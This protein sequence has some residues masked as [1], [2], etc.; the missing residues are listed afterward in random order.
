MLGVKVRD[1]RDGLPP[2]VQALLDRERE[3]P[4]LQATV[5]ARV[6]ARARGA[7]AAAPTPARTRPTR[8]RWALVAASLLMA[9][10]VAGAAVYQRLNTRL[11]MRRA[12]PQPVRVALV[13]PVAPIP[14]AAAKPAAPARPFDDGG[15]DELRLLRQA[16]AAVARQDYTSALTS[17]EEHARRF[18]NGRLAEER[19]ALRVK[20]LAGL[21][22]TDEARREA[23]AFQARFPR[24]VLLPAVLTWGSC[25]ARPARAPRPP[26]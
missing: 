17:L 12:T 22:R 16:R 20:A 26:G 2:E 11:A 6:M 10:A 7:S 8:L 25:C 18:K 3:I 13:A 4:R 19:G 1:R 23:L 9:S 21:G 14:T 24:S 5:R 15:G